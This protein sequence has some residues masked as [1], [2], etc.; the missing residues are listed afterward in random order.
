MEHRW[1][2]L[3]HELSHAYDRFRRT[4][5][6]LAPSAREQSGVCGE[7]SPKEV[8]AHLA[9]WDREA[10]RRFQQF[11]QG[12]TEDIDYDLDAFNAESV[13][14][15]QHLAWEQALHELDKAHRVLQQAIALVEPQHLEADS[16]FFEWLEGRSRDYDEHTAQIQTWPQA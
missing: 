1:R 3:Q 5:G 11:M 16:R 15:R 6:Q 13:A 8:V 14:A 12:P 7:W 4:V 9:G 2:I 10:A